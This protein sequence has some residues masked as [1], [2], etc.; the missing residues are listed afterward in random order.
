MRWLCKVFGHRL[1]EFNAHVF[2]CTRCER[3]Y[4]VAR[5]AAR[6]GAAPATPSS[7]P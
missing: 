6:D 1:I 2:W 4:D 5:R 3:V 7:P